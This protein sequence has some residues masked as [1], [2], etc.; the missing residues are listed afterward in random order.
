MFHPCNMYGF[1][2]Y[3]RQTTIY[4]NRHCSLHERSFIFSHKYFQNLIKR[5][6]V[7]RSTATPIQCTG[8]IGVSSYKKCAYKSI[9]R[10]SKSTSIT[11][12]Y[13]IVFRNKEWQ[14]F[15]VIICY[16]FW[17][18]KNPTYLITTTLNICA[19]SENLI[20]KDPNNL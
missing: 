9:R 18:Q 7:G 19:L 15:F 20:Q 1:R 14:M 11:R 10:L 6:F 4:N 8:N 3:I 13:K 17:K 12:V 2:W 16:Q 5:K